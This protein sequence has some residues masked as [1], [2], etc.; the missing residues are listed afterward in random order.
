MFEKTGQKFQKSIRSFDWTSWK[1][2]DRVYFLDHEI[3]TDKEEKFLKELH[4]NHTYVYINNHLVESSIKRIVLSETRNGQFCN[5]RSLW[6]LI[7]T[8]LKLDERFLNSPVTLQIGARRKLNT[9]RTI[10]RACLAHREIERG[11]NQIFPRKSLNCFVVQTKLN[12]F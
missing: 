1:L 2:L 9:T 3:N 12:L 11:W 10:H 8:F 6:S 4:I 5:N 7:F